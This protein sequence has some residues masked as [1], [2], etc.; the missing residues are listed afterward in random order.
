[1]S[2]RSTLKA[3]ILIV[4]DTAYSDPSTDRAGD[5]LRDTFVEDGGNQ[6]DVQRPVII[7]DKISAIQRY[8]HQWCDDSQDD[9]VNLIV[10]T[11]GTGFAQKDYTPEAVEQLIERHAS[12]LV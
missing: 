7:P 2:R 6:W 4:S 3:A 10:T 9:F 12:G 11:G 1:M 5:A 8:I